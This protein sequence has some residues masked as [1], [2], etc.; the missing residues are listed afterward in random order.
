MPNLDQIALDYARGEV[1]LAWVHDRKEQRHVLI[2][3]VVE[4][5]PN[6]Q[7]IS[8]RIGEAP[9][10]QTRDSIEASTRTLYIRREQVRIS[11]A[12]A[13]FRGQSG[14]YLLPGDIP[15]LSTA[16]ALADFASDEEPVLM[17]SNLGAT[18]GV[19][20][21]LP[22]RATSMA[23]V[24][25]YDVQSS[26]HA[27]LGADG[28]ESI[29]SLVHRRIGID[30]KRFREH[31]GALHLCFADPILRRF[32]HS[33]TADE[34]TLLIRCYERSGRSIVGAVVELSN[35][36]ARVG[37]GF[38][39]RHTM[40]APFLALPMPAR[41][42]VL[43]VRI[44]G[45]DGRC[46]EEH[47]GVF[48]REFLFDVGISGRR[49]ITYELPDGGRAEYEVKTTSYA[50]SRQ[51][52]TPVSALEHLHTA[53]RARELDDLAAARVF[54]YFP[55][56]DKSRA[57]ALAV[58]R[59][60]VGNA[61]ARCDIVDPY[62][63]ADDAAMMLPF[64]QSSQCR[65]RLISS[66][67]YL[68]RRGDDGVTFEARLASRIEDLRRQLPFSV[69]ARQLEG[70]SRSPVHDRMLVVD[71]HVYLLG[72]SLTE[73][74]SRATTIFRIQDPDKMRAEVDSWW[75]QAVPIS[76]AN[77]ERTIRGELKALA[78]LVRRV[79]LSAETITGLIV[80]KLRRS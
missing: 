1:T 23:V 27:W 39:E 18:S 2:F 28:A 15:P 40:S 49:H 79:A 44:F 33:I 6:D 3:A 34:R 68:H 75:E 31:V 19:G 14:S 74:G 45:H 26:T 70:T 20:A 10:F 9:H 61:R 59:E 48:V 66:R 42:Q 69:Q 41:P 72:S 12:L 13:F 47:S 16:G 67:A 60:L 30:L 73:F 11:E 51:R 17:Q 24:S 22:S 56:G 52:R 36:W 57:L 80:G 8:A 35:E 76:S 65:V 25:K 50:S 63:S 64:V 62:L 46:I 29:S 78:T 58:V 21:V 54:L 32:E 38:S 77:L 55:G 4:L 71:D 37:S 5:C 7:P 43:R 53:L